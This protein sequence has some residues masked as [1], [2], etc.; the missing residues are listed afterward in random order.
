MFQTLIQLNATR[1]DFSL[2]AS[3]SCEKQNFGLL[4]IPH[5]ELILP[6]SQ[7]N[8]YCSPVALISIPHTHLP[9]GKH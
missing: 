9:Y 7:F 2:F 8:V 5:L 3:D 4:C 6:L 1:A